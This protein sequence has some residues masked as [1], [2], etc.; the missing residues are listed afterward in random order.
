MTHTEYWN[1]QC[2]ELHFLFYFL[3][4]EIFLQNMGMTPIWNDC[5]I[6]P[7][8]HA[9]VCCMDSLTSVS[10]GPNSHLSATKM[11]LSKSCF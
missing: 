8:V 1:F 5:E 3:E 6:I 7:N 9:A 4:G 2:T 11:E 10:R